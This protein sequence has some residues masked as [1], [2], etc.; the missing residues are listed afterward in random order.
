MDSTPVLA[1]PSTPPLPPVIVLL[2]PTAVGK[3]ELSLG[4]CEHFRG[5]VVGADSRQIYRGMD[6]GTAKPTAAELARVP[7]HLIDICDP[8]DPFSLANY[9]ERAYAT[10]DAI[11]ARGNVPFLVGGT[12]LYIRAVVDGLR[13]PE[14]PPNPEVRAELEAFLAAE[15]RVAL[16]QRLQA[17]DPATAAVIDGQNPR[18]VLRA[19]EIFLTTGK[20]KVELEGT[21]PPLYRFLLLGLERPR[22]QLYARIDRR[23]DQMIE[24]GLIAE[25]QRLLAAGYRPPLP[26][27]TSL[28]YREIIAYLENELP[29]P[30]A[31]E[32]I[33]T[34]THRYVRHQST[35]FRKMP[36]IVW[37]TLDESAPQT[38][39]ERIYAHVAAFLAVV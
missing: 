38:I 32:K 4:L 18:R 14:A 17:L 34:E 11:H 25:T 6:I 1:Q 3:T 29:L 9:Q 22:D 39:A 19:L 37:F 15:G 35:W 33:K 21:Q 31:I 23:V 10:I 27:I 20:A 28:G 2:G 8:D 30:I 16:F 12:A 13:I 26:A 36:N 7:H 24:Q 5:E